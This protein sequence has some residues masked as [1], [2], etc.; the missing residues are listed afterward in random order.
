MR[1]SEAGS[2]KSWSWDW[3]SK[4][5]REA[6]NARRWFFSCCLDLHEVEILKKKA[7][8]VTSESSYPRRRSL[9]EQNTREDLYCCWNSRRGSTA[10]LLRTLCDRRFPGCVMCIYIELVCFLIAA[11]VPRSN[12]PLSCR[13]MALFQLTLLV[14]FGMEAGGTLHYKFWWRYT[15]GTNR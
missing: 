14:S 7:C 9:L 13:H 2:H 6:A 8:T 12:N 5:W 4:P 10:E 3:L 1:G 15:A 11:I